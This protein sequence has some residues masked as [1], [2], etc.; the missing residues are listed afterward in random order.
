MEPMHVVLVEVHSVRRLIVAVMAKVY[1]KTVLLTQFPISTTKDALM[2]P[3]CVAV[4][5]AQKTGF[6]FLR[7]LITPSPYSI[8][9]REDKSFYKPF[10]ILRMNH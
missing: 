2:V 9:F 6:S 10:C 1:D 5:T 4:S 7:H 8:L 3:F